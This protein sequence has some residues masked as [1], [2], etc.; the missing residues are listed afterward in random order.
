MR[1]F[2]AKVRAGGSGGDS[3]RGRNS[4]SSSRDKG[5]ADRPPRCDH[6]P[7]KHRG[8]DRTRRSEPGSPEDRGMPPAPHPAAYA[9]RRAAGLGDLFELSRR[10]PVSAHKPAHRGAGADLRQRHVVFMP[11]HI[12][13]PFEGRRGPNRPGG[14]RMPRTKRSSPYHLRIT[15]ESWARRTRR[16]ETSLSPHPDKDRAPVISC[17]A[18]IAGFPAFRSGKPAP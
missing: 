3:A 14:L 17:D 13:C 15:K 1:S 11:Q 7:A 12:R 16:L 5:S 2:I 4:P 8:G 9:D 10:K 6:R 18:N